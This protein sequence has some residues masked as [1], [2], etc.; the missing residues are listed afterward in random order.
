MREKLEN[1][2]VVVT[3][4]LVTAVFLTVAQAFGEDRVG[5][6]VKPHQPAA[7]ARVIAKQPAVAPPHTAQPALLIHKLKDAGALQKP[8]WDRLL[9][10]AFD[11]LSGNE[12]ELLSGNEAELLSDNKAEILSGNRPKLLSEISP[13]LL[14]GNKPKLLSENQTPILSGNRVSVLSNIKVEIHITNSGNNAT[15][16]PAP[17]GR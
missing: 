16:K 6:A 15:P 2:F 11:V 10:F 3:S 12:T 14:S 9:R 4:L 13:Q 1:T 5:P 7:H 8:L 17:S